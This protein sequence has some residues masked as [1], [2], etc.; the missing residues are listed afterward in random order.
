MRLSMNRTLVLSLMVWLAT[1][2]P[3]LGAQSIETRVDSARHEVV[4]EAGP[5]EV[6]AM[7]PEMVKEM[8]MDHSMHH[9]EEPRVFRF[10]WPVDGSGRA[11]KI[12]VRDA[13]G[14]VIPRSLLHHLIALNFDRRQFIYQQAERL[15]GIGRETPDETLPGTLMVPLARG[16][17]LGFY[18]S[19]HNDSGRDIHGA[20]V[21]IV[22]AW[23]PREAA[24]GYTAVLPVYFDVDNEVGNTNTF[25]IPPGKSSKAFDFTVPA[26]GYLI[27]MTG[28]LH[29]YGK[30]VRLEDAETGKVMVRLTA[31]TD[32]T[33]RILQIQHKTFLFRPLR[34]REGHHYR[35]VAEYDSPL[36][37]TLVEGAM[38]NIVG[39]FAPDSLSRWPV[40]DPENP[41]FKKDI[42]SLPLFIPDTSA[43]DGKARTEF[44][45]YSQHPPH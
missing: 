13:N 36:H 2:S 29:D 15:F 14:V 18:L 37:N 3:K 17:R 33:G 32:S 40:I 41:I 16:Q 7:S 26:S 42:A 1:P 9:E 8:E 39:V 12:E 45:T 19:W 35:I 43:P 24:R 21:R 27:A 44:I 6:P 34:L 30:S 25:D 4:I 23:I 20:R 38:A 31:K 28:H 10:D 5:F 22:I 11:Y